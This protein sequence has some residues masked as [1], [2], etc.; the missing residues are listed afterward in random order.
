[1]IDADLKAEL[2]NLAEYDVW[3]YLLINDQIIYLIY[4]FY[5]LVNGCYFGGI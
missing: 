2:A 3:P 4:N 5:D 1:M